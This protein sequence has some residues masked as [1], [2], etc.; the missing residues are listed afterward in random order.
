MAQKNKFDDFEKERVVSLLEILYPN[1]SIPIREGNVKISEPDG[2]INVDNQEIG[3][4]VRRFSD[5]ESLQ[6]EIA[7]K[8]MQ[9][10]LN[11]S[12]SNLSSNVLVQIDGNKIPIDKKNIKYFIFRVKEELLK[13][14]PEI[15]NDC[16]IEIENVSISIMQSN[17]KNLNVNFYQSH[18]LGAFSYSRAIIK[19]FEEKN[20]KS[21]STQTNWLLLYERTNLPY[22][23]ADFEKISNHI[24]SKVSQFQNIYIL[25]SWKVPGRDS[26]DAFQIFPVIRSLN[27][28]TD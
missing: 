11:N 5:G 22:L 27:R 13:I 25:T 8:E 14:I 23:Y 9:T 26:F 21:Y 10:H 28:A 15:K 7:I 16:K 18:S 12:L 24:N 6:R 3:I 17:N 2:I 19:A 4:E 20:V 1:T